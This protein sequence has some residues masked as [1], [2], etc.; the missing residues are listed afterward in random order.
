MKILLDENLDIQLVATMPG[1]QVDHVKAVGWRG[2]KNGE[3]LRLTRSKYDVFVTLDRG[4]LFQHNHDGE[5]LIIVVL[6]TAN[7]K[8]E[9]IQPLLP[10]L[11]RFLEGAKEGD[12]I[13][14]SVEN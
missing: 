11:M 6:R 12:R 3:L 8:F 4:I 13:E 10:K 2:I 7:S 5:R 9:T 14:L 1:H